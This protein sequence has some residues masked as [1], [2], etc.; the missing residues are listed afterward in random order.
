MLLLNQ[1]C[2]RPTV[3]G[4]L[5]AGGLLGITESAFLRYAK[6]HRL[7]WEKDD[8]TGPALEPGDA[9]E[10]I[11][12]ERG[13]TVLNTVGRIVE[14]NLYGPGKERFG[15]YEGTMPDALRWGELMAAVKQRFGEAQYEEDV[16]D[17]D[18]YY[19][20][21][22][23]KGRRLILGFTRAEPRKLKAI[24]IQTMPIEDQ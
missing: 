8:V 10:F 24:R 17:Q 20:V 3:T 5:D 14:V 16:A 12:Y 4:Q 22:D 2:G 18:A 13:F 21:Y 7:E 19:I 6:T 11:F 1:G 15:V 9:K 23:T